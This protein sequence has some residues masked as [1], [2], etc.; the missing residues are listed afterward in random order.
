MSPSFTSH[1]AFYQDRKQTGLK[2]TFEK[3]TEC[4]RKPN[5]VAKFNT[6]CFFQ[7]QITSQN[8]PKSRAGDDERF[9]CVNTVHASL[10]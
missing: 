5:V 2:T 1:R 8:L 7:G 3:W 4:D 6:Q 10:G 9:V